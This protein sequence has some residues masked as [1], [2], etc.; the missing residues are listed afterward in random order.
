MR[1]RTYTNFLRVTNILMTQKH[2]DGATAADLA[3]KVFDHV[4]H[5]PLH[6]SADYFI[7]LIL[8]LEEFNAEYGL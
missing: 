7:G 4:E 1:H 2:Y 8:P 6:R 5:D 3:S